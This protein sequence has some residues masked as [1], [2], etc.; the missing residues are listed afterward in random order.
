MLI[1]LG[2][3]LA[4]NAVAF[5]AFLID[6]RQA[7]RRRDRLSERSLIALSFLGGS[8]GAWLAMQLSQHKT[9]KRSFQMQFQSV[10]AFQVAV[11]TALHFYPQQSNLVLA[12][13]PLS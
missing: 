13:L 2:Y 7:R 9:H 5:A 6:K 3:L 12:A 11:M 8:L 4:V 10:L 1:L